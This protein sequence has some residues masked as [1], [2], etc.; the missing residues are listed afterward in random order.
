MAGGKARAKALGKF[1]LATHVAVRTS[2][3]TS[4]VPP[5]RSTDLHPTSPRTTWPRLSR[6]RSPRPQRRPRGRPTPAPTTKVPKAKRAGTAQTPLANFTTTTTHASSAEN[7]GNRGLHHHDL[8]YKRHPHHLSLGHLV[9]L[10][11]PPP[12]F[13]LLSARLHLL[14]LPLPLLRQ[15]ATFNT[16]RSRLDPFPKS[17]TSPPV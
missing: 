9:P 1:G 2:P 7:V 11:L 10:Q 16:L 17:N 6:R 3:T 5:A 14:L 8:Q 15:R 12:R 13:L 4:G